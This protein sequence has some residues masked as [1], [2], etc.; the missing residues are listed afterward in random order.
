MLLAGEA[1]AQRV[2]IN[3]V[4]YAP[5]KPEPE[6]IELYNPADTPVSIA[7]WTVANHL[8][9]YT[10]LP[11]TISAKGYIVI[12]KD[13]ANFLKSKYHLVN[14]NILQTTLPPLGNTGD[15]II[16]K[17]SFGNVIDSLRYTPSWG[18][19]SSISLERIDH[20]AAS[21]ST[22]FGS[23]TDSLGATPCSANSIRR[24]DFDLALDSFSYKAINPTD[25]SITVTILNK[26]RSTISDGMITLLSN[27]GL[28]IAQSQ[29]PSPLQPLQRE[30]IDLS[31]QNADF[32]KTKL[33][34]I[35]TESN[36]ELHNNDTLYSTVY[37]PIP[38]N[39]ILINEIMPTP[40]TS[41]S[42]WIELY[43]NSSSAANMDST[44]LHIGVGT[45]IYN[46]WINSLNLLPK[47]Y[48]V[49]AADSN[50]FSTFPS[51]Q[52]QNG[53]VILNKIDLKLKDSG[54]Q[55]ILINTDSSVI[56]SL[57][58]YSNWYPTN[59]SNH[60]GI[61][62][63]RRQFNDVSTSSDNWTSS[64]DPSGATPLR[65]NSDFPD[66][67]NTPTALDIQITPNPFSP[68]GDG[69]DDAT[70]ISIV[71]PSDKIESIT[72]KIYDLRGRIR[73][74]IPQNQGVLRALSIPFDGKDDNGITLPIG[75]YTLV[76]ESS[77]GAFKPQRKGIVIMK[78]PR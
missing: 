44:A 19:A 4:M 65:K 2:V 64:T 13:S 16:F 15:L 47:Q 50:F 68:D 9:S 14:P 40:Q 5:I 23:C 71:I 70:I 10:L 26:G 63:E 77:D 54:N 57:H 36:D 56:D 1:L 39:A 20:L 49:I 7:G 3:E 41:S 67:S 27:S 61:S 17:D 53:I 24:R 55:I 31:W 18:G 34:A 29:I 76:I 66:S 35:V 72:A 21:D 46:F 69:F 25:L 6:W 43:N 32:G 62:L 28:P 73:R 42:E 12:T 51:L 60:T 52:G 8:R 59:I 45:K 30:S 38:R 78:K 37:L 74:T 48:A 75:L 33:T 11:D 22:N 58:D